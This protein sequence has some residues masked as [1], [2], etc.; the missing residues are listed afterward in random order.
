MAKKRKGILK[1]FA[2]F[3]AKGDAISL[4]IGV[5]VGTSFKAVT[6][7]LVK[8]ILLP[9]INFFT[10]NIDFSNQYLSL[11]K[12]SYGS[13]EEAEAAGEILLKYGNFINEIVVFLV[14]TVAIFFFIYKFQQFLV[15]RSK[16]D[17]IK[18]AT[19]KCTYCFQQVHRKATKCQHCTSD[20]STSKS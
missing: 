14:T 9:P 17:E 8:D 20:I 19:R 2:D 1:E 3:A 12:N 18:E 16:K 7:S 13:L 6:D 5:V 15:K 4:A 10:S 11:S